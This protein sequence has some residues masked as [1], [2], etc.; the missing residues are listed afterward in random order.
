MVSKG[1]MPMPHVSHENY[2]NT[3]PDS[4][5]LT[6]TESLH[7]FTGENTRKYNFNKRNNATIGERS[8]RSKYWYTNSSKTE[9]YVGARI[10][11]LKPI[12]EISLTST[13]IE[14]N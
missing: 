8:R 13:T 3:K 2:F 12:T 1:Y 14:G 4:R 9:Q 10:L 5:D 11:E 7:T 6:H